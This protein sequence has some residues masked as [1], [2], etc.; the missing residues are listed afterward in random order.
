MKLRKKE[1]EKL[2]R[3]TVSA[4]KRGDTWVGIRPV[5]MANRKKDPKRSR[6]VGKSICRNFT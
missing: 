4:S 3:Q 6:K 5:V 2:R 1:L